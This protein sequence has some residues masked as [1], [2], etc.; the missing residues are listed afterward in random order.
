[1]KS[2]S[3]DQLQLNKVQ[4]S[5]EKLK[6]KKIRRKWKK[7]SKVDR[8]MLEKDDMISLMSHDL[9]AKSKIQ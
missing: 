6:R 5:T 1:V 2:R 8:E 9:K 4:K 3:I 7:S